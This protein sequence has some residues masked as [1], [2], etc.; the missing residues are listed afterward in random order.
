MFGVRCTFWSLGDSLKPGGLVKSFVVSAFCFSLFHKPNG[1]PDISKRHYFFSNIADNL[2]KD[3]NE[4]D[5]QILSRAFT[6]SS[7]ARPLHHSNMLFFPTCFQD[8]WFVFI[9]D[10]KDRKYVI[11]DSFNKQNDEFQEIVRD[12]LRSSFEHHWDKYMQVNMCFDEYEFVYP[13]VPEQPLDNKS[14]LHCLFTQKD[15]SN[16]RIKIANNL[17]FQPKNSGMKHRVTHYK[18]DL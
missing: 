7:K 5:Q 8:H 2:L 3:Y 6:K 10:I 15:I 9:V 17:V 18:K 12:R 13:V 4:A 11:L 1:H 14:A 16:I